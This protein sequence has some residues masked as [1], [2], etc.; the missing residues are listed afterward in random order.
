M[1]WVKTKEVRVTDEMLSDKEKLSDKALMIWV[2]DLF[3][4]DGKARRAPTRKEFLD[5]L[6]V[7]RPNFAANNYAAHLKDLQWAGVRPTS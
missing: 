3:A 1:E 5:A 6:K 4:G 2:W 7:V